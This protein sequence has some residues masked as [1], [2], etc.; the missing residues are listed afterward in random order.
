[1]QN[2]QAPRTAKVMC[3]EVRASRNE[4]SSAFRKLMHRGMRPRSPWN[5]HGRRL[6]RSRM[7]RNSSKSGAA[8]PH[9]KT[10]AR[11]PGCFVVPPG[12]GLRRCSGALRWGGFAPAGWL[13]FPSCAQQ[14]GA[15]APQSK[16]LARGSGRLVFPPGFGVRRCSGAF[17]WTCC[18]SR[19]LWLTNQSA[20]LQSPAW[21]TTI[22][23]P[24][25]IG[26][27]GLLTNGMQTGACGK[28][29]NHVA[30]CVVP[31]EGV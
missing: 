13:S 19:F 26:C 8:A 10:L 27:S 24:S 12:F 29:W 18:R 6:A 28:S 7:I 2:R 31:A 21:T 3:L 30:A 20:G 9:S 11:G 14:S 1:M 23:R 15:A 25:N 4:V 17:R 5:W 22:S 16:T